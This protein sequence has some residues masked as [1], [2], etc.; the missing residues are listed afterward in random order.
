M[1]Q[2]TF[3]SLFYLKKLHTVCWLTCLPVTEQTFLK[4]VKSHY[5]QD[6]TWQH[7]SSPFQ[8]TPFKILKASVKRFAKT[9]PQQ[10]IEC[11]A[12]QPSE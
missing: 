6:F 8:Y 5:S 2:L 9:Y 12:A 1:F 11:S 10:S 7:A 4:A 3:T